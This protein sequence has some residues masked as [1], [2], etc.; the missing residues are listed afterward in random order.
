MCVTVAA[1]TKAASPQP[2]KVSE[3]ST[4][5]SQ[6]STSVSLTGNNMKTLCFNAML[7]L[8]HDTTVM[9]L[10][11]LSVNIKNI[12]YMEHNS[13]FQFI[14]HHNNSILWPRRDLFEP[15]VKARPL[16]SQGH[17]SLSSML[18]SL[19]QV[20]EDHVPFT[21]RRIYNTK[22]QELS[23][24]QLLTSLRPKLRTVASH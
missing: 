13:A 6:S 9:M 22:Q 8:H 21:H 7:R 4:H 11:Q 2:L 14:K 18:S 23:N 1:V 19:R 16:R 3:L 17:Q 12:K 15:K 24:H 5:S 20:F 10:F